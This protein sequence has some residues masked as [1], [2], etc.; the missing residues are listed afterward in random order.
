MWN[1]EG[2]AVIVTGGAKGIGRAYVEA[3]AQSG[4]RVAIADIDQPAAENL[5][6]ELSQKGKEIIAAKVDV[7][8]HKDCRSLADEVWKKWNRLD[9]L[10]NNA[11]VYATIKR[12][13][14]TDIKNPWKN[15][16]KRTG[17]KDLRFHDLRHIFATYTLMNSGDLVHLKETLGHSQITT[18]ARYTKSLWEGQQ[19]LVRGFEIPEI[20]SEVVNFPERKI[21]I[22]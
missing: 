4:A 11:A 12:K 14:F 8:K 3:F 21:G 19:K 17:I 15:L 7:S 20:E 22:K 16:L 2:K 10:V 13:P 5:A 9:V 1:F 18:T 6:A